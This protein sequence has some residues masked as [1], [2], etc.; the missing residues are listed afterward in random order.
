MRKVYY[1]DMLSR[2]KLKLKKCSEVV[3]IAT[4]FAGEDDAKLKKIEQLCEKGM[5]VETKNKLADMLVKDWNF[6]A[7]KEG[8]KL[9]TQVAN[10]QVSSTDCPAKI[11]FLHLL[12]SAATQITIAKVQEADRGYRWIRTLLHVDSYL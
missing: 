11:P 9:D 5:V 6:R 12:Y 8:E 7:E 3:E 2:T 4:D 1:S 10:S